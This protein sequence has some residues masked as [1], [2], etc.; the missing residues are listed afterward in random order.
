M[1]TDHRLEWRT[2]SYSGNGENCVQV[3]PTSGWRTSSYSSNGENCLQVAH[4]TGWNDS[5]SVTDQENVTPG[6]GAVLVRHSKH[7]EAGIIEF[8]PASW[9]AFLHEART[10]TASQ[11]GTASV[12]FDGTDTLVDAIGS[13]IHLRFDEGEWT[14]FLAGIEDG[15]FDTTHFGA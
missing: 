11:N 4:T 14:A 13:D 7:P 8:S 3:A 5:A 10:G 12:T 1:A 9:T 2:S 15:E 6:R